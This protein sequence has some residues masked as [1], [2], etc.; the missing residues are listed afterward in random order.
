MEFFCEAEAVRLRSHNNKFL[1][2][3]DDGRSLRLSRN[4]NAKEAV[5]QVVCVSLDYRR[6]I[7]RL[8]S[9]AVGC[10]LK[11]TDAVA[12][13]RGIKV[14]G[15]VVPCWSDPMDFSLDWEPRREGFQVVLMSR[16][17][18]GF[19]RPHSGPSPWRN[20]VTLDPSLSKATLT[21]V[22]IQQCFLWEVEP[23]DAEPAPSLLVSVFTSLAMDDQLGMRSS[24]DYEERSITSSRSSTVGTETPG[25][26]SSSTREPNERVISFTMMD[27]NETDEDDKQFS[28]IT[29]Q[30][31]DVQDMTRKLEEATG[32]QDIIVCGKNPCDGEVFPLRLPLPPGNL[33]M[34]VLLVQ[35]PRCQ[36]PS[37]TLPKPCLA[38]KTWDELARVRNMDFMGGARR[39][40]KKALL[41]WEL[42]RYPLKFPA[43]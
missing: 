3:T 32:L 29:F 33:P 6:P 42:P 12:L 13:M 7:L 14:G 28:S 9:R 16:K 21:A 18:G 39:I 30:G 5:W 41:D 22:A 15:K 31:N 38:S 8:K 36:S 17:N 23:A 11:A 34:R 35:S 2:V 37:E 40:F 26:L 20:A 4:G 43:K 10:F 25:S 1:C 27:H 19:L 24:S